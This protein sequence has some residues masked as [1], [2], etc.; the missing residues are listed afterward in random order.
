VFRTSASAACIGAGLLAT[1]ALAAQ[2]APAPQGAHAARPPAPHTGLEKLERQVEEFTLPNGL[3][4]LLVERHEAPV[5]SFQTVVNA[6][7]ADNQVGTTGL[8][9][10]MEH[11][12]FKGT[13]WVGT[14]DAAAERPLLDAEERA[15]AALA[16]ERRKGLRA[17]STR[18][19]SLISAFASAEEAAGATVETEEFSRI[20]ERAGAKDI[21]AYTSSDVTAYTYSLPSNRLELWAAM[22]GGRLAHP[23]FREFYKEREVVIEERR[24][25]TESSP[26]GRLAE[27]F[28]HTAFAAHPYGFGTIGFP[29]DLESFSRTQGEAFFHAHYVAPNMTIAVV[30]DV[31]LAALRAVAERYFTDIPAGPLPPPVETVEPEQRA[32][33]RAV[34][35]DSAQPI[36]LSGWHIP[37][38]SDPRYVA[39]LALAD[40]L[41]GGDHARLQKDLVRDK[42][43]SVSEETTTG[44]PGEKFPCI[45]GVLSV[46][47]TGVA[48]DSVEREV[49]HVLEDAQS[50]HPFTAAELDGYKVRVRA[51]KIAA[52]E[53]NAA[54]AGELSMAQTLHGDWHAFFRDQEHAQALTPRDLADAMR[55]A[56]TRMNRTTALIVNPAVADSSSKGPGH[57]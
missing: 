1:I 31:T 44:F 3:R 30:G 22:E 38:S 37:A 51:Q 39:Y 32:E 16:A 5:F 19:R 49:Y 57:E 26:F 6:G 4:F 18:L 11:M 50:S 28:V 54:L 21:N 14:K 15:Y 36:I 25:T 8:A 34:L 43:L 20:L 35:E 17:D 53:S 2:A 23:V 42:Q 48:P 9:H 45:W 29:S 56:F 10:M 33:R 46:P 55:A 13:P 24:M 41:G 12:A 40:L 47:A 27:E 7:S 52:V